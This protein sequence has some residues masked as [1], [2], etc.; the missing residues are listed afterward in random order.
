MSGFVPY[1]T[2][3]PALVPYQFSF[4][5]LN[6]GGL[7]NLPVDIDSIT[8]D[9]FVA[10]VTTVDPHE[11]NTGDN[12]EIY[13]NSLSGING[14]VSP[15]TVVDDYNYTFASNVETG[16]GTGGESMGGTYQTAEPNGITGLGTPKMTTG[17]TQRPLDSGEF[18]GDD[19]APGRDVIVQVLVRAQTIEDFDAAILALAQIMIPQGNVESP[20]FFQKGGGITYAAMARPRN[21]TY[22]ID[23]NVIQVFAAVATLQFH[24]TDWR[25]YATPT[26]QV[27]GPAA[28][29]FA[30]IA[31]GG[32][33]YTNPSIGV[34][35]GD[36]GSTPLILVWQGVEI[37]SI[38]GDGTTATVTTKTPHGL[39]GSN[40][41]VTI[42]DNTESS[43]NN[44][45]AFT[46]TSPTTFTFPSGTMTTGTGGVVEIGTPINIYFETLT[47]NP[48]DTLV[49]DTDSQTA[50]WV[51]EGVPQ[52]AGSYI[53]FNP[54]AWGPLLPG[55]VYV[56]NLIDYAD[57]DDS[58]VFTFTYAEAFVA[59]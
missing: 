9:A 2:A 29:V 54:P 16:T 10:T 35:A 41:T 1:G 57:G 22:V 53:Y 15:V 27:S 46:V 5:S 59:I 18:A 4:G 52:S 45:T 37:V 56:V 23:K 3:V 33:A 36:D 26:Q 44:E 49:V 11:L 17:D 14:F 50:V 47:M 21:F 12:V 28:Q 30:T 19:V 42:V 51:N 32:N 40:T 31:L 20:L 6:F 48:G 7:T 39:P 13:G 8:C 25:W 43:F 38:V 34:T 24:M 55:G 58:T